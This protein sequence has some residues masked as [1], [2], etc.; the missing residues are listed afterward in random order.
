[1]AFQKG[2]KK[3]GGKQKGAA[4]K[5]TTQTKE[6]VALFVEG[7]IDRLNGWLDKIAEENPKDAFNC[8]MSVVEYHI[9]KLARQES[10]NTNLNLN[11]SADISK[12]DKEI[13]A[14]Y[15]RDK[16]RP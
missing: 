4:N 3:I 11:K 2:H 15:F 5:V 1:M 7:N 8:F 6:A 10:T 9:P 16:Q 14:S 12:E 13:I